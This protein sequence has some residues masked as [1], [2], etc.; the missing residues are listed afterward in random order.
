MGRGGGGA[1]MDYLADDWDDDDLNSSDEDG[2]DLSTQS[3]IACVEY[4]LLK[5]CDASRADTHGVTPLHLVAAGD[6]PE[7]A[8]M[9]LKAQNDDRKAID[10]ASDVTKLGWNV[11]HFIA[12]SGNSKLLEM[13]QEMK[14]VDE[15]I[16][17][18]ARHEDLHG[19]SPLDVARQ[20][21]HDDVVGMLQGH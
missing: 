13:L 11:L 19:C 15:N 8:N 10:L 18:Q 7:L 3:K 16:P 1:E 6:V 14:C 2:G 4:L 12:L 17:A 5:E 9:I 20:C 21:N